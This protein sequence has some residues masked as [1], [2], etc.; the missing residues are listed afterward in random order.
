MIMLIAGTLFAC[1]DPYTPNL[2]KF[3][4]IL[5]VDAMVTNENISNYVRLSRTIK[6]ADDL[7]KMVSNAQVKIVDDLGNSTTLH[8]AS[9]GTYK[10]DSLSFRGETGRS[11]TLHII[12]EDGNEYE[13]ESCLMNPVQ[14]IDTIYFER[15]QDLV[16]TDAREGIRIYLDSK[17]E[18]DCNYYRWTYQEWWKF[19]TPYPQ[20][21]EYVD[22]TTFLPCSPLKQTCWA[23]HK[24]GEII[25]ETTETGRSNKFTKKPVLFIAS[26]ESD[27]L[28]IEYCI[29]IRQLSISKKEYEFWDQLTQI[30][31]SGGDIFDK[32]PFQISGNIHNINKPDEQVLGYF[33]VSGA[34]VNRRFIPYSEISNLNLPEYKY[35]CAEIE[36]KPSDFYDPITN[37]PLPTFA[38]IYAWYNNSQST[39]TRPVLNSSGMLKSMIFAPKICA[40]CTL[41]G[42]LAKPYF[43]IDLD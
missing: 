31:E 30:N 13:S 43:W 22:D 24:S 9:K 38:M 33:Q 40:D 27:R 1:I 39:F 8:E 7:P 4:S 18:S 34:R 35:E 37:N 14:N 21:Y 41:K 12:T 15:Y 3:E 11:Y 10:T 19:R 17:G 23:D 25:I 28:L 16:N 2:K 42:S 36:V 5:V 20:L 32:Q 6:T 29:Q 26:D